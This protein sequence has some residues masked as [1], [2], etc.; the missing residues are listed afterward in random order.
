MECCQMLRDDESLF[1]IFIEDLVEQLSYMDACLLAVE[2]EENNLESLNMLFRVF[3]SIKGLFYTM[4][5]Q[6]LGDFF[7]RLESI[8]QTCKDTGEVL[9]QQYLDIVIELKDA[10]EIYVS[11]LKGQRDLEFDIERFQK[12]LMKI[13]NIGAEAFCAVKGVQEKESNKSNRD[14]ASSIPPRQLLYEALKRTELIYLQMIDS[15]KKIIDPMQLRESFE[16]C[17]NMAE[18]LEEKHLKNLFQCACRFLD[19]YVQKGANLDHL[20]EGLIMETFDWAMKLIDLTKQ[21]NPEEERN[22]MVH[23]DMMQAQRIMYLQQLSEEGYD[24]ATNDHQKLGEILVKQG[25][26][27]ENEIEAIISKQKTGDVSLKLGE[28]LVSENMVRVKDIA[29]ALQAQTKLRKEND[30]YTFI[31]IP[32][33]KV[34]ILVDGM[35]ELMI[36]QTQ[37]KEKLK[38][39]WMEGDFGTKLQL[40]RIDR[41]LILLQHQAMSFRMQT[42]ENTLQKIEI[43]GRSA[44]KDLGKEVVFEL[45]GSVVEANRSIIERLQ[46]PIL[47]LVRNSIYHGIEM[48][49]ERI[50]VGKPHNG[51]LRVSG[52]LDKKHLSITISDDGRGLDQNRILERAIKLGLAD[53]SREY[54]AWEIID[55]IF[56]PGFSTLE[57]SDNISGRGLGMNIV[58]TEIK[59]L[60]GHIEIQNKP[61]M[62]VSFMLKIPLH[63]ENL[64]GILVKVGD[65]KLILPS[66]HVVE[67]IKGK[68]VEWVVA[69]DKCERIVIGK[70]VV[71]LI[72]IGKLLEQVIDIEALMRS[73]VVVLEHGGVKKAL[74]VNKTFKEVGVF[75]NQI[76]E[77]KGDDMIF[78]GVSVIN[79]HEFALILDVEKIFSIQT[80]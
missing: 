7:H 11:V 26:V 17:K 63:L 70:Q 51:T 80:N 79:D 8:V 58:E 32:E 74:P 24:N 31:R 36:M 46:N 77:L 15:E 18:P 76:D 21:L 38:K 40:D 69:N 45:E 23:M 35:E 16:T 4:E 43:I 14:T 44:A 28:A 71:D 66:E 42:L 54:A 55:F 10:L 52:Y 25:K 56:E 30:S 78:K 68:S 59:A 22:L 47:H 29:G 72:P 60:G 33:H 49:E 39:R 65:E 57:E 75:V 19:Y 5:Y 13:E 6:S 20:A 61:N 37:L 48:P 62:G 12:S 9:S 2:R 67:V 64:L 34:D 50:A 1:E 41:M 27:K 3:H 73:E 53:A